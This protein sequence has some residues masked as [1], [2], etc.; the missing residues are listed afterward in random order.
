MGYVTSIGKSKNA[1]VFGVFLD[2]PTTYCIVRAYRRGKELNI[3]VD[4]CLANDNYSPKLR[5]MY[6]SV[7]DRYPFPP[8]LT[9]DRLKPILRDLLEHVYYNE[10]K[11]SKP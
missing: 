3:T 9:F 10:Y 8:G 6:Q 11:K 1:H 4:S 5:E 7:I 2:S